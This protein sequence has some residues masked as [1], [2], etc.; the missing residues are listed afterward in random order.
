MTPILARFGPRHKK[1]S[2]ERTYSDRQTSVKHIIQMMEI[3]EE[4]SDEEEDDQE[5]HQFDK[6]W[7]PIHN[8]EKL[9]T[10]LQNLLDI[11][12]SLGL[13]DRLEKYSDVLLENNKNK[14]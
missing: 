6:E 5:Q 3:T 10:S 4:G 2:R 9:R 13:V 14:R 12:D 7:L 11:A 1:T 8:D